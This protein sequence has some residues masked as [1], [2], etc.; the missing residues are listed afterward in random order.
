MHFPINRAATV[1]VSLIVLYATTIKA[2]RTPP[3]F[4][5]VTTP[6]VYL[7]QDAKCD[8]KNMRLWEGSRIVRWETPLK[9]CSKVTLELNQIAGWTRG[10]LLSFREPEP[11]VPERYHAMEQVTFSPSGKGYGYKF[12]AVSD[13]DFDAWLVE[14]RYSLLYA[15]D[16]VSDDFALCVVGHS[17]DLRGEPQSAEQTISQERA[18]VFVEKLVAAGI[19]KDRL[20]SNGAGST[21][22]LTRFSPDD[23]RQSRISFTMCPRA[24]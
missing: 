14:Y 15:L 8:R 17:A 19:P 16:I 22:P 4:L 23:R 1:I 5:Y 2:N 10:D 13:A 20:R 3:E 24:Q 11:G 18:N 7:Y 21:Q 9:P 6:G 12:T